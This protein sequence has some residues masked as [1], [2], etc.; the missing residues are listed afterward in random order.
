[1]VIYEYE[2]VTKEILLLVSFTNFCGWI[3]CNFC[4]NHFKS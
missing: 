3:K 2:N 4:T 1:M